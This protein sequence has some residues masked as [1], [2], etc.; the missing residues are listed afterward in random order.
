MVQTNASAPATGPV[1]CNSCLV[2]ID[3]AWEPLVRLGE[4]NFHRRCLTVC[5]VCGGPLD[6]L[7]RGTGA[8]FY[9]LD[10]RVEFIS[11]RGYQVQ[12]EVCCC[13]ACYHRAIHDEPC[14][15][16]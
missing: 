14:A 6:G 4:F 16:A 2:L 8:E 12:L 11:S 9:I 5:E 10:S 1:V 15:L 7:A 3:P 13:A